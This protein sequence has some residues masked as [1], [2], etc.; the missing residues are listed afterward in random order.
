MQLTKNFSLEE[1]TYSEW[2]DAHNIENIPTDSEVYNLTA[3][4]Q[5]VLQPIRDILG[6][7]ITINSGFR[8]KTVNDGVG[9]K[10]SSQH[11]K[12]E[13]A[14]L[15]CPKLGNKALYDAIVKHGVYDQI[16][17]EYGLAWVHV[18]HKADLPDRHQQLK[19]K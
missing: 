18:S 9:S 17:N 5:D 10:D 1:L 2:T 11:R 19:I 12:G 13:A 4:A 7:P 16:I 8:S 15:E 3:L 6:V 14:D